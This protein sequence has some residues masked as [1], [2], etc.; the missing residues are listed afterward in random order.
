MSL[1]RYEKYKDSGV[2]WL[3]KVPEHWGKRRVKNDF[4]IGRGRVI[5]QDELVDEGFYPVFS[6]QTL[7][8]G[9]LGYINTFDFDCT[10]IT[11]TTDG[12]NAGTVFLRKGKHN[13][14]NVCGTLLPKGVNN[15]IEYIS[16]YLSSITE[17]YKRPD[18]N[19]AKIMNN[20]MAEI[21]LLAPLLV[22]QEAIA[23]FLDAETFKID[24]LITEQQKLIELLKEKRQATISHAVT[25]GL[26]PN[27]KMKDSGVEW[28]G[29][30]PEH[31]EIKRLK[32]SGSEIVDC[33]NRTPEEHPDDKYFVVR[34]TCIRDG[35]FNHAGGFFTD[36]ANFQEWTEKGIPKAGDVLF[37]RE[38]PM[39]EACIAPKG[40]DFC[41][42]QRMMFIRPNSQKLL[43]EYLLYSIYGPLIRENINSKS[44]GS[45]VGHL[46]VGEV[47]EL[48]LL[49]PSILEQRTIV[50]F[51]DSEAGKTDN[52]IQQA[53]KAITLLQE[54]RTALISAAVTGKI[55]VRNVRTP[56]TAHA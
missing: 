48:P 40:L 35:N 18:T 9:C 38:A 17:F 51:L 21:V 19:G 11:W 41:L 6:S 46:R 14:T 24:S 36:E 10:Q 43:S 20:E 3:G 49:L 8:N 22:E 52:L 15:S 28:L 1:P 42:G 2:E 44:K 25:K 5:S 30:V 34:T 23:D 16:Y 26:N 4:L 31:W 12:A 7:N 47:G 56:E 13:C 53:Q 29:E 54:R 39:G 55:D 27:A 45:T 50:T 32:D 33:K 37:T